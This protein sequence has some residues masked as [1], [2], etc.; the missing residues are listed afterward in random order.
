MDKYNNNREGFKESEKTDS[1]IENTTENQPENSDV[2]GKKKVT[3]DNVISHE[4]FEKRKEE[5]AEENVATDSMQNQMDALTDQLQRL[6]AEF[7]NYKKRTN[8][9]KE[10]IKGLAN[11]KLMIE[12]IEVLDNFERAMA[13]DLSQTPENS[14]EL[15]IEGV[16]LIYQNLF[17]CLE[18]AG[19]ERINTDGE[20]DPNVHHAVMR[21]EGEPEK[22]NQI[23]DVFQKG[24][25]LNGKVIRPS[26]V[27][28]YTN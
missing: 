22:E 6:Q 9:E 21:E 25:S 7:M 23:A 10:Q 5:K 26:M 15:L 27:K 16:R 3:E 14:H 2:T 8:E 4:E 28:V 13:T 24:Y 19:L 11:E 12:L 17:T 18:H 20:F 1:N